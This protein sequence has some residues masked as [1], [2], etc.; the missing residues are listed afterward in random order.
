MALDADQ[1]LNML[2]A[3]G[4][5]VTRLASDSRAVRPGDVFLA[6][7]GH[8]ADGRKFIADAVARGAAAVVCEAGEKAGAGGT[9][10]QAGVPCLEVAN[11]AAQAGELAHRVYGRPSEKLWLAG[12]TGTNGKTSV[13]QWLAQALT[14]LGH[15]C[16]VVGTLGNGFPGALQETGFTT[17]DALSLHAA[18]AGFVAG[19]ADCCAMEVSSIGLE[20]QRVSGVA[21]DVAML[22]NLTRDHLDYHGTMEAYAAAKARLF[23][24]LGLA[25]AVLNLDDPLGMALA[26][27][28][29]GRVH[30]IGYTLEGRSGTD[31]VLAAENLLLEAHG[32]S[33]E[34]DGNPGIGFAAPLVGRFNASNLL[35]VIGAL[36]A[37]NE[38]P[39]AI[40]DALA[41]L[42]PPPGRMQALGGNDAPLVVVDYAHTP[43]ALEKALGV[44]REVATARGG[45]LW[46]VFGCGGERDPG[47]RPLMGAA[48]ERLADTV[49]VT[50]DNPRGEAP[51][52]II[53]DILREMNAAPI[54]IEDRAAAIAR[55]IAG[56]G[57]KDV[58][59]L[60]G[61][62]H[63]PYQEIAGVRLPFS[64]SEAAKAALMKQL[65]GRTVEQNSLASPLQMTGRQKR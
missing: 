50:S 57:D 51:A 62:G 14:H 38:A 21:F 26:A 24:M 36:R 34:L 33:F 9:A 63:E 18:L 45:A 25:A 48:A 49:V 10:R 28:L 56:A 13:S 64:D 3:Q 44:L 19:G 29:K 31:Q 12:V 27:S 2:A 37:R 1:I 40:A 54:V 55:A 65:R 53:G 7:P 23:E 11:L 58:I 17:P 35:A 20:E 5:A 39:A 30:T 15:R 61:K 42:V 8:H 32:L 16:A 43:D 52:A 60:A 41:H 47:K 6:L 4:V 59:L 22:T 46:C